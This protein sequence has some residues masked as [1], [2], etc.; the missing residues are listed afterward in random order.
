EVETN[1]KR[2]NQQKNLTDKPD[3]GADQAITL[4]N[5]G[6]IMPKATVVL[7]KLNLASHNTQR[8]QM[9]FW[10]RTSFNVVILTA[11][12]MARTLSACI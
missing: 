9:V 5:K 11:I 3:P 2:S 1:Y 7:D 6:S 8:P 12:A 10:L 4:I